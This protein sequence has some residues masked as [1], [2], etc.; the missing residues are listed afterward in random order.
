MQLLNKMQQKIWGF[1]WS[2]KANVYENPTHWFAIWRVD[3]DG[4]G[5]G[6][7]GLWYRPELFNLGMKS[8]RIS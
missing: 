1:I 4:N 3:G 5:G 2:M 8:K 7:G 6:R